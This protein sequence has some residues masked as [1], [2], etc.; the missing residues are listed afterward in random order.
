LIASGCDPAELTNRWLD[1]EQARKLRWKLPAR[2]ADGVLDASELHA[3]IRRL[4][5]K[6]TP[7]REL[8]I[9][10]TH[11]PSMR[12]RLYRSPH[13]DWK[14]VAASCAVPLFLEQHALDG[15]ICADGGLLDPLPLHAAIDMGATT[16]VAVN[17]LKH[18]PWLIRQTVRAL[19][20]YGG[21]RVAD[22]AGLHLIEISP[23]GPMGPAK[24]S[25][26][27][28]RTR[29]EQ[30]IERGRR[31]A[32]AQRA[33]VIECLRQHRSNPNCPPIAFTG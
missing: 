6:W 31:D 29:A 15:A 3:E 25:M 19:R 4:C 11:L 5:G 8:G 14:H 7:K 33:K 18:R 24:H 2:V 20:A 21:Y 12:V 17:L 23:D 30:W 27:W 1:L 26:Y 28:S 9:V 16:I 22:T 13:L 10:V 32:E